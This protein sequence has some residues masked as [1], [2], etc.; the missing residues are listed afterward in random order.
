MRVVDDDHDRSLLR[1]RSEKVEQAGVNRVAIEHA[2]SRAWVDRGSEC[3]RPLAGQVLEPVQQR[4]AQVREPCEPLLGVLIGAARAEDHETARSRHGFVEQRGLSC[5]R[6]AADHDHRAAAL[7]RRGQRVLDPSQLRV[8]TDQCAR[9]LGPRRL[10]RPQCAY[11]ARQVAERRRV[12][13]PTSEQLP[14]GLT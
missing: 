10:D 7:A 9:R 6:L 14:P 13:Q 3:R 11:R 4:L 12:L 5:S 8:T 2:R 1:R